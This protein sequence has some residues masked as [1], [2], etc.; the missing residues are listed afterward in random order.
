MEKVL[1]VCV[2]NICR[3]PVGERV[4]QKMAPGLSVSSAGIAAL[5]GHAADETA[6]RVAR[7]NDISLAGHAGRQFTFD[8]GSQADL[9]LVMEKGH[10]AHIT[11]KFPELSG[12]TM[13]FDQWAK[14]EDIPDPFKRLQDFH[15]AVFDRIFAAASAW[16]KKLTPKGATK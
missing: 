8:L 9:I 5:E 11:R 1:V 10:K 4:L 13:L 14:A 7:D 2:G 6:E 15:E 12:K 3:S 16:A